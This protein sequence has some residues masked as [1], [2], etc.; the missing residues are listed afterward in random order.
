M[1]KLIISCVL[2]LILLPEF[3]FINLAVSQTVIETLPGYKGQLPF[4]LETGYLLKINCNINYN[5]L[6]N[7]KK[8]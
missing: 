3:L 2:L 8:Q 1:V 4:K 6:C 5:I 7:I